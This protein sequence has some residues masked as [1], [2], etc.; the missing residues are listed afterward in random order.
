[1]E[2]TLVLDQPEAHPYLG[3][4]V[5]RVKHSAPE[6]PDPLPAHLEKRDLG[7]PVRLVPA[8]HRREPRAR[9]VHQ[10]LHIL[11]DGRGFAAGQK[12]V[13]LR[14]AKADELRE[15]AALGQD[16]VDQDL[17]APSCSAGAAGTP[18]V[19]RLSS[20]QTAAVLFVSDA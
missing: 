5:C 2:G 17:P 12:P 3:A 15:E 16:L 6:D 11:L 7:E 9:Q 10:P 20:D 8:R 18:N 14:L 1:M 19:D 13:D 4:M